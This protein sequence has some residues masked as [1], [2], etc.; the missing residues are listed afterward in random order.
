MRGVPARAGLRSGIALLTLATALLPAAAFAQSAR[1]ED[2]KG[3]ITV[4]A[5]RIPQPVADVPAT[6][7]VIDAEAIADQMASDI[8]DLVRFE[9]GVSVHRAPTRFGAAQGAT[10][11]DGN[12][13]FNIRGI[14]GNRVLIQVDGVRVPDGFDFGAQSAGRGDYVDLGVVKSVEILRG[15]A[16]AL[17]GSD[18]LTGAVSFIT[19]DPQ[20]FLRGGRRF[21][22]IARAAYDSADNQFSETGIVAGSAG[23][24][25]AMLAYTRRDGHE[26][27]DKGTI[28]APNATR[29]TPN[30]Q[31]TFSNAL[32]GKL[33]WAPDDHNRVRLTY[34]HLD[35]HVRTDVLSGVAAVASSATSVIGLTASDR[36]QRDRVSLDW[37]YT[38]AG[39]IDFAQVTAWYQDGKNRQYTA[40]DRNTAADR[41]RLNT[42]ENRVYGA[43]AE[44]R[45][46]F[47][48]GPLTHRLVYGA[49]ASVTR[50]QGVRDG[51]VPTPPD[52]FPTRA[53]PVTDY[54]LAGAYLADEIGIGKAVTLY[55]ALRFDYYKLD[56]KQDALLPAFASAGQD[57]SRV[58]PKLGVVVHPIAGVGLFANYARGFKA[59]APTQVN[60][61]FQN[62][63]QGYTSIPNPDL[64]PETSETWEGGVKLDR[65]PVSAGVTAFTG[66]YRGFISQEVVSGGF[67]PSDPAVFQFINL[68]RV[69]IDGVEGRI[70][71]RSKIG[72]T[73]RFAVG[74]TKGTV[75]GAGGDR[76]PLSTIDP[77]KLVAGVGYD[78]PGR[79]FGGEIIATHSAQKELSATTYATP[80]GPASICSGAGGCFRPGA[81]T[82]LD[83]TAYARIGDA[84][85]LRAGVFNLLDR[86]YA[87]WSD[88]RGLAASS[89]VTDAYT[90]PGRNASVSLTVRF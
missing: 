16:S 57:G 74:Y 55:P 65:G 15:P 8:K 11:R 42:F 46:D 81:F 44:L 64:K 60:Q 9:A 82:I 89:T 31:D 61:F 12:S 73:G 63:A 19:S 30:P 3:T 53:F 75:I 83:A 67:T 5:T 49:D 40:E 77:L 26:L 51:T 66:R 78:A 36:V 69:Q 7:T 50:Q 41:T 32:L 38:G 43:S 4:T 6:V 39:A 76:S 72:I 33:V 54:T 1:G 22:G 35:D 25:S 28:D 79:R 47:S 2:D 21:G 14:D 45:S 80:T 87:W 85:T 17:Y 27:D 24:W 10:G 68:N 18:G 62:L 70:T 86:K 90:Q 29:T 48:T 37:R 59:P 56:P 13:G 88:V 58:S 20:D 34:D 52:V 84:F 23:A 71:A